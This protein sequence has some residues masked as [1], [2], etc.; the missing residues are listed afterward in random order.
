MSSAGV[1]SGAR[2]RVWLAAAILALGVIGV[3]AYLALRDTGTPDPEALE[4]DA[5]VVERLA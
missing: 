2:S 1:S 5:E 3:G 4:A